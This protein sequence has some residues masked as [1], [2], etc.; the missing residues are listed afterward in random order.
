[1]RPGILFS[2][3]AAVLLLVQCTAHAPVENNEA[4]ARKMFE[5]F[6]THQWQAM[7]ACYRDTASF[8][9]PSLGKTYVAQ[10]REEIVEKYAAMQQMFSDIHDEITGVYTSGDKVVV[11]FISTGTSGDSLTF[12]LPIVTVL[13]FR[14]GLIVRD[15]TYYDLENP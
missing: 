1:M 3:L 5:A 12:S 2:V 13:T 11:E 10:R 7:A 14:D 4:A 6:N 15:A 9:D 8:L